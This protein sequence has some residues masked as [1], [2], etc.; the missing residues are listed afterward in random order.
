M[1]RLTMWRRPIT[2]DELSKIA[3]LNPNTDLAYSTLY[4]VT[5]SGTVQDASLNPMGGSVTW[6]FTTQAEPPPSVTDTTVADFNAGTL[7]ACVVDATVGDGALRLG[8]AIDETF[9]GTALPAGWSSHAWSGGTPTVSGGLLT[10]NGAYA[11]NDTLYGP[12]RTL[13]FVATF[14]ADAYQHIG[15]GANEPTFNNGPWI[16]FSTGNTGTQLY[17]R[18]V[19]SAAG[20]YNTGDDAIG[21]GSQYLG[22]PHL[23][24]IVWN[25]NSIELYIDGVQ[26]VTRKS[27]D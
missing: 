24:R 3:T 15:F 13:E 17:A 23:Y 20:P 21:L 19:T 4:H 10:V 1:A 5:V 14:N 27:G 6:D 18:I 2:Y 8:A 12:G 9:S 7:D 25:S 16:M 11:R 22:S 26:V